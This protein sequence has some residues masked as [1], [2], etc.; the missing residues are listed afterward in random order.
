VGATGRPPSV[1]AVRAVRNAA[2]VDG[3]FVRLCHLGKEEEE[4]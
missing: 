2:Q 1:V 4:K 3:G